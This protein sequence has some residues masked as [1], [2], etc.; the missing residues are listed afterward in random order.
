[1]L[2]RPL[3]SYSGNDPF[4]FVSYAREDAAEV[5]GE[6]LIIQQRGYR[7]WYDRD[8]QSG[9][10][11]SEEIMTA[12]HACSLFLVYLS[13]ESV[14]STRVTHQINEA[15]KLRKLF[16]SIHLRE[17][18]LPP[19]LDL[20]IGSIQAI[21]RHQMSDERFWRKMIKVLP[22][23]LRGATLD[24]MP[25]QDFVETDKS[26]A[27]PVASKEGG[28]STAE[29]SPQKASLQTSG[30]ASAKAPA[31]PFEWEILQDDSRDFVTVESLA[32]FYRF[33]HHSVE[34]RVVW[35]STS[36]LVMKAHI[37]SRELLINNIKFILSD[38]VR[39]LQGKVCF[40]R[41]D[42]AK[43]IDPVLRPSYIQVESDFNTVVLDPG[44]G[45]EQAGARG[46]YGL[47]KDF[48]LRHA[49]M[50][51]NELETQGLKV[52]MTRT[53]DRYVP[54]QERADFANKH[55]DGV[56]VGLEF[57]EGRDGDNGFETF[58]M[59]PQGAPS[60][61]GDKEDLSSSAFVGNQCDSENIALATAIHSSTVHRFKLRDRG[62][63]R[64]RR[65]VLASLE[66]PAVIFRGGFVTDPTEARLIAT[67]EYQRELAQKISQGI[68]N[69]RK[70]VHP[71][72]S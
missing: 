5:Y 3:E 40:S 41:L 58:A 6:L 29:P 52:L 62:V 43:L 69:F 9:N 15:L 26:H 18:T 16:L 23:S 28:A 51:K 31:V 22:S 14:S 27:P 53:D 49:R 36:V 71:K 48:A 19:R 33:T 32:H 25:V 65:F 45:G 50:I 1:M 17:T 11:L 7:V 55:S 56:F 12:L 10:G 67:Q 34:D 21:I 39:E 64:S 8:L 66:I 70:G 57:G 47:G 2:R 61:D 38:A 4:L 46:I 72:E 59:S 35:L 30:A 68:M 20:S 54:L 63:K 44:H 60:D 42:L 37:G 24:D 13:P